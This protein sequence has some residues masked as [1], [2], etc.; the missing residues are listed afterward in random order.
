MANLV[1]LRVIDIELRASSTFRVQADVD[2][3]V[4]GGVQAGPE[5]ILFQVARKGPGFQNDSVLTES[6]D[7]QRETDERVQDC[8]F[9]HAI[10][11]TLLS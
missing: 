3:A 10:P 4:A 2:F 7:A 8:L 9:F 1:G 5:P 6:I 11:L